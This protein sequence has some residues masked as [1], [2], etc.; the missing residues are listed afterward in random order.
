VQGEVAR[1]SRDG[2]VVFLPEKVTIVVT[3]LILLWGKGAVSSPKNRRTKPKSAAGNKAFINY[4]KQITKK[5]QKGIDSAR[6]MGY[7]KARQRKT[8]AP[9]TW[10][11]FQRQF[12]GGYCGD[13]R[14]G[15]ILLNLSKMEEKRL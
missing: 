5:F 14:S 6:S 2:R 13:S 10:S 8:V 15:M 9:A 7:N 3:I 4:D 1:R 12:R 11:V